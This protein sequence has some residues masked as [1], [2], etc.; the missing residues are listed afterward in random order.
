VKR[1]V[2]VVGLG[3]TACATPPTVPSRP[4]PAASY[5]DAAPLAYLWSAGKVRQPLFSMQDYAVVTRID[6]IEVPDSFV[7]SAGMEPLFAW[8]ME[9]PAGRHVVELL[10]KETVFCGPSYLGP[11]CTVTEKSRHTLEFIAEP[12]RSYTPFVDEKCSRKWFWVGDSGPYD[13]TSPHQ[14]VVAFENAARL[15]A[16]DAAPAGACSGATAD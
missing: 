11:A 4:L 14:K 7:P 12:G 16:G 13:L 1:L 6:G 2:G 3:L 5:V 15:V 8:G 10:N 9:I